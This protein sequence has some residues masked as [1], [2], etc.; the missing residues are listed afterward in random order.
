M[1]CGGFF[2]IHCF[3]VNGW[4]VSNNIEVY[5]KVVNMSHGSLNNQ[6]L[7]F[8]ELPKS[9]LTGKPV[10][11]FVHA[12][13]MPSG[14][15]RTLFECWSAY[16]SIEMI[17]YFGMNPQYPPDEGWVSLTKQVIDSVQ[18]ACQK[19]GVDKL[20]A[21]GHS[22]GALCTLLASYQMPTPFARLVLFDPPMIYGVD[23]FAWYLAKQ[24][25]KLPMIGMTWVDKMSPAGKSKY[26][27]DTW[28]NRQ[29]AYEALR[30]KAFFADFD[31]RCF[32]DY[33][34]VGL[35]DRQNQV[36]LA[37]TKEVEVAIFRTNPAYFW[38]TPNSA[39]KVPAMILAG[40]DS[41]MVAAGYYQ[42]IQERLGIAY[43]LHQGGHMFPLEY[44]KKTAQALLVLVG[45]IDE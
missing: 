9:C 44:P 45:A 19:H 4:C 24:A 8:D 32:L 34:Q 30:H 5:A 43:Q 13:G 2:V 25:G 27:K 41:P 18:M 36:T 22:A 6:F 39:P 40:R 10:L 37:I 31:E 15:Y 12:N 17:E 28:Q 16:F 3:W 42:Q 1:L 23:S 38:R 11:H 7:S 29:A 14:S 26:R 20:I 33:L 35:V 21:I